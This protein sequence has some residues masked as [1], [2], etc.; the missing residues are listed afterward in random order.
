MKTKYALIAVTA[1]L[2]ACS[3]KPSDGDYT[4][5]VKAGLERQTLCWAIKGT[6]TGAFPAQV[7]ASLFQRDNPAQAAAVHGG[8]VT[9]VAHGDGTFSPILTEK[10]QAAH[11]WDPS[12]G[13]CIGH[14]ELAGDVK[15]LPG[16]DRGDG[17][18]LKT[19]HYSW[20]LADVPQWV[21]DNPAAGN[22]LE[23]LGNPVPTDSLVAREQKDG[24]LILEEN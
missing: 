7:P 12:T 1:A 11:A 21:K 24:P 2:A 4:K 22:G 3:S 13:I 6:S 5:A 18:D 14:K 15:I 9:M 8:L 17:T 20:K 19:V 23:G 10:G 16:G